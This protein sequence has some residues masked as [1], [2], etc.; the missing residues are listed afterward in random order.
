MEDLEFSIGTHLCAMRIAVFLIFRLGGFQKSALFCGSL[1]H[2]RKFEPKWYPRWVIVR[3]W[4]LAAI[5]FDDLTAGEMSDGFPIG[6][7]AC[8]G[9]NVADYKV[10][11]RGYQVGIH[12]SARE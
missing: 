3:P 6:E 12:D 1:D 5:S 8:L 4:R 9:H 7:I 11:Q 10:K 2:L